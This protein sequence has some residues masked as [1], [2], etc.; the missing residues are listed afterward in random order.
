MRA[1]KL[2]P[3]QT[4]GLPPAT[5]KRTYIVPYE[6]RTC[7]YYI[8]G[9]LL[10]KSTPGKREPQP[11]GS[12]TC[13]H[14]GSHTCTPY[15]RRGYSGGRPCRPFRRNRVSHSREIG[16]VPRQRAG[17]SSIPASPAYVLVGKVIPKKTRTKLDLCGVYCCDNKHTCCHIRPYFF[18]KRHTL[19]LIRS[20]VIFVS[21]LRKVF[22]GYDRGN[23]GGVSK[24]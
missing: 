21:P 1:Q 9:H 22:W 8:A 11:R 10:G 12:R 24:V 15:I 17:Y 3:R 14:P 16:G 4:S 2:S 13:H 18:P 20:M 6:R 5:N 19:P 23:A 7:H